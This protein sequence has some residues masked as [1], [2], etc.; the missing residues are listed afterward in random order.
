MSEE[1]E[2]IRKMTPE[3][4]KIICD[5]L[6]DALTHT[7]EDA[8]ERADRKDWPG[9]LD[10]MTGAEI[11]LSVM[12]KLKCKMEDPP[13]NPE[14]VEYLFPKEKCDPRSFRMKKVDEK[15]LLIFCCPKGY[16]DEEKKLCKTSIKLHSIHH[17]QR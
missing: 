14:R 10:D 4:K 15:A 12:E 1:K 8:I 16:W 5:V 11:I 17:L 6:E 13:G 7:F 9:F 2:V 3:A